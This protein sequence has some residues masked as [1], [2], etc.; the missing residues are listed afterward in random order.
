MGCYAY[1]DVCYRI[2]DKYID[3]FKEKYGVEFDGDCNYDGDY[4]VV[5]ADYIDDLLEEIKELKFRL[6]E[7]EK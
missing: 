7:L 6:E 3:G 2:P 5:T 4:W 1:K